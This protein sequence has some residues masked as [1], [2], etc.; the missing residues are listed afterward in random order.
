MIAEAK[1]A[2]VPSDALT[3]FLAAGYIPQPKQLQFHAAACDA[4]RPGAAVDIGF[5]GAR[6]GGKTHT[7]F[8]QVALNDCQQWPGLKVLFLRKVAKS[9]N[10]AIQDLRSNVLKHVPHV[11]KEQKSTIIFPNGSRIIVGHFKNENDID[12]YLGLEYDV[13]VIEEATQLSQA[14]IE[15]IKTCNRTSKQGFR[16]RR[17][18]TT[19]PGGVGHAWFKR[20]FIEPFRRKQEKETRFIPSLVTDNRA[21][22]A[23]YRKQLENLTGWLRDAWLHGDWDIFAGQFFTTFNYAIH[24][25]EP[26]SLPSPPPADWNVW[27]SIDYGFTHY[28]VCYLFTEADGHIYCLDEHYDRKKSVQAHAEAIRAMLARHGVTVERLNSFIGGLDFFAQRGAS[29][30][31]TI[32]DQYAEQGIYLRRAN[33]DRIAGA[34]KVLQLLGDKEA[35]IEPTL[36]ISRRCGLLIEQLPAMQHDPK[37]PEDVLKV[38]MDESGSGGDDAYDAFRYGVMTRFS[39]SF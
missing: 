37:R 30:G 31:Q 14:K 20:L 21:V 25:A 26:E 32:A 29:T 28:T 35:G 38:N 12:N 36:T 11:Y 18:Y 22:N 4:N 2:G 9:A 19:N 3:R 16:P 17:Y 33:V 8:A 39:I 27:A 6:G 23:D 10:E 13:I 5:G 1:A 7:T 24:T 15:K 34:G